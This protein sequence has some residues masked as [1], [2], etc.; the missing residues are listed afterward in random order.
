MSRPMSTVAVTGGTGT[1]GREVVG[2]LV[3][4]GHDVV[5]TSRSSSSLRDGVRTVRVDYGRPVE[6][7]AAFER[8]D[9]VVH[10]A[11]DVTGLRG[12][13]AE[14]GKRVLAAAR[15]VGCGHLV[16]ISIVGADRIPLPYYKAKTSTERLVEDGGVP[17]TILRATQF[18]ELV[19][20]LSSA[21]TRSPLVLV[22]DIRFQPVSVTE[23]GARL[24]DLARGSPAGRVRDLG[25][26]EIADWPDLV[27]QFQAA[28]GRSRPV[29]PITL[30]G[31]VYAGYRA[32][33]H[34]APD[35]DTGTITFQQYLADRFRR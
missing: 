26:P 9:A 30:F 7:R 25:G 33:H 1:L 13:E 34:L 2:A 24:A 17:W 28:A 22:P 12:G 21:L 27:R 8:A 32:G 3:A 15:D 35:G 11:T 19:A 23:V 4:A 5:V 18:H 29:R 31:S 20:R 6:L 10:C 14:L 16:Y